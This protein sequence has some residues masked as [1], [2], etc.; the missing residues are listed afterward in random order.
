M[1]LGQARDIDSNRTVTK[2]KAKFKQSDVCSHRYLLLYPYIYPH[3]FHGINV[4]SIT[5]CI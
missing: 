5:Y 4:P 2:I 3:T 1:S